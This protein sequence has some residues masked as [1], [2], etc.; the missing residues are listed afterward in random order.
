MISAT[1]SDLRENIL[2]IIKREYSAQRH[3]AKRL[4]RHGKASY[5]TAEAW[6][7]GRNAPSGPSL[8]NIMAE[9]T[10]LADEV[11]RL[12]AERKKQRG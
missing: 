11:M 4:A 12:V 9:C 2:T 7:A 5:R 1:T 10:P 8:M 3:A 6:L